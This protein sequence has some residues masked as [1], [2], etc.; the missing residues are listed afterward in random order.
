MLSFENFA[1]FTHLQQHFSPISFL[2]LPNDY[3]ESVLSYALITH[4]HPTCRHHTFISSQTLPFSLSPHA[5]SIAGKSE[6]VEFW[7]GWHVH[8]F[9]DSPSHTLTIVLTHRE[10][11]DEHSHFHPSLYNTAF[12]TQLPPSLYLSSSLHNNTKVESW[13]FP[14]MTKIVQNS[15]LWNSFHSYYLTPLLRFYD[16]TMKL[17]LLF[18]Q[19]H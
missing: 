17:L 19:W 10:E 13:H 4:H 11:I 1:H 2:S 9:P 12:H 5:I 18:S 14:H 7:V 16:S 8:F 6:R 15:F 3:I